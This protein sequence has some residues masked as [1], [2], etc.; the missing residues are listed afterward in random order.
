MLRLYLLKD[1]MQTFQSIQSVTAYCTGNFIPFCLLRPLSLCFNALEMQLSRAKK[2]QS[3]TWNLKIRKHSLL[4]F[5]FFT[6]T[7]LETSQLCTYI[8]FL[9]QG[10]SK[11]FPTIIL[12]VL[13]LRDRKAFRKR[14]THCAGTFHFPSVPLSKLAFTK[15]WRENHLH[16]PP[17]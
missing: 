5:P 14:K 11:I 15:M 3:K 10:Q 4:P 7:E 6:H 12:S 16:I 13:A 17:R 8:V 2:G 1:W 9:K